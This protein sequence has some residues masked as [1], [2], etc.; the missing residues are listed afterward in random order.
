MKKLLI[1][2]L[3]PLLLLIGAGAGALFLGLV[4]G[5]GPGGGGEEAAVE[6]PKED[7]PPPPFSERDGPQVFWTPDEF[8]VNLQSERRYPVFL[9]L[10]LTL[11][12]ANEGDIAA[13][14]GLEPRIRDVVNVYLS[15]LRPEDL[16]GYDGIQT[17]RNEL[18]RRLKT[19]IDD[20]KLVNIQIMKMT[21]K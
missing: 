2:I 3:L 17:T 10:S 6:E 15:S 14:D 16:S 20:E 21:V 13:L 9:L 7:V 18:W 4:P 8:V 19:V 11:E 1:F 5:L 12:L